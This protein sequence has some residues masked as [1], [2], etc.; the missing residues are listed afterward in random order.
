VTVEPIWVP[1]SAVRAI[2]VE[3]LKEHGGLQ[4]PPREGAL[5]AALA[6][7]QHLFFY[8][9]KRATLPTLAASY[10]FALAKGHCFN[11]GNKRV[12]MATI[13]VFLQLNGRE[14]TASEE[15]AASTILALAA[16]DITESDLS[17]WIERHS[18]KL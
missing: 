10:G 14:L 7:P 13:D 9:K 16:G 11:D 12:A 18:Q 6:R 15:D 17:K 5:E 3:L 1:E 8:S 4:G 2:H